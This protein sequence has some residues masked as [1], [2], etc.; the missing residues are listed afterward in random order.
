MITAQER[1]EK[2]LELASELE[3]ESATKP[4]IVE[5][6]KDVEALKKMGVRNNVTSLSKGLS[7]IRFCED[8]SR[9]FRSV[10]V[11]TDWDR[12]GGK[13]ARMLKD[14]FETNGVKVDLD[15]RAKLVILSKKEIKDIE[16]LPAFVERLRRMTEKPR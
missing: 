6:L 13:L 7:I 8:V 16:G 12:K 2:I 15:L 4:I 1:L 11:L 10:V 9:Q 5:G 3:H 14:A